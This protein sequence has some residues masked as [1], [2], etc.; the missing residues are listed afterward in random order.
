MW[1]DIKYAWR[2][3]KSKPLFTVA[4]VATIALGIG[5]NTAMFAVV[6]SVLL[7]P[8]PYPDSRQLVRLRDV[9]Q[10][11][12]GPLSYAEFVSLAERSRALQ[13]VAAYFNQNIIFEGDGVNEKIMVLRASTSLLPTLKIGP[14]LG[15]GFS[16]D[17]DQPGSHRELML[18]H[19]FW[20]QHYRGEPGVIGR[21]A[22]LGKQLYTVVGV[23]PENFQ[24]LKDSDALVPLRLDASAAPQGLHFLNAVGR[25]REG[26]TPQRTAGELQ[27]EAAGSGDP[28]HGIQAV[29]LQEELVSGV[30]AP[31]LLLFA[32]TGL[33]LVIACAN[34]ANLLLVRSSGRRKELAVRLAL[35][36][37]QVRI[38]RQFLTES[39]AIAL[40]GGAFGALLAWL[41]LGW[42]HESALSTMPRS[43]E[44]SLGT[45][46][47]LFTMAVSITAGLL[48]GLGAVLQGRITDLQEPLRSSRQSGP[49]AAVRR[50]HNALVTVEV[51]LTVILLS[52]SGLLVRSF[53]N[54]MHEN[55]GFTAERVLYIDVNLSDKYD[56]PE[57]TARY[58]NEVR[59]RLAAKPWVEAVGTVN[60]V[61]LVS[62]AIDG[63]VT[64]SPERGA[65][66]TEQAADKILADGG[67]FATL[68]I[69]LLEGR[70]FND[71]D[72][73]KSAPVAIIDQSLARKVCGA[74][75]C[76]GRRID[77][78]WGKEGASEIVG[79]VGAVR[80]SG[81]DAAPRPTM[82][83][84]FL[85]KPE[86]M[87]GVALKMLARVTLD[88]KSAAAEVRRVL[89]EVDKDQPPPRIRTMTEVVDSSL[90]NRQTILA[91]LGAFTALAVF[92]SVLGVY[93]MMSYA[94]MTRGPEFG[95]RM[96]LGAQRWDVLRLVLRHGLLLAS[97]GLIAGLGAAALTSRLLSSMLYGTSPLDGLT[98]LTVAPLTV[99][100]VLAA[101]MIPARRALAVEPGAALKCE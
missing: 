15:P 90:S 50:W 66:A 92:L 38:V 22:R 23:L 76:T 31:A 73:A 57:R 36:A 49:A 46:V 68:R 79:V 29:S 28:P 32:A 1:N 63:T 89:L 80:Q 24:F 51:A 64:V 6:Y 58:F 53:L 37:S 56:A 52:G 99:L 5:A 35:G 42:A 9:Q 85:Q 34:V 60:S 40:V 54:L 77:F 41:V 14:F 71:H 27:P 84:P 13:S 44:V 94:V 59:N 45:G 17:A 4:T 33:I 97:A 12:T 95:L 61:P 72:S 75:P 101:A 48:F 62:G 25:M 69:P 74:G 39:S 26:S 2:F 7:R 21:T 83:V 67:Y 20:R 30:R 86:L 81:L 3:L 10:K 96:A 88:P 18:G 16:A 87:E 8:L 82:Y 70:L 78:G 91:L 98:Y 55:K 43:E 47:L 100:V 65:A 11:E 93:G 19:K